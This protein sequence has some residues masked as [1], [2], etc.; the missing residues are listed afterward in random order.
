MNHSFSRIL[1]IMLT[2]ILLV[3]ALRFFTSLNFP[4]PTIN[5]LGDTKRA[6]LG[7]NAP[8][9]QIV[10]INKSNL[11]GFQI[12]MGDTELFFGESLEFALLD[13]DC[14]NLIRQ[15]KRT[16]FSLPIQRDTHFTFDPL[17]KSAGESYCLSVVYQPGFLERKERPYIRATEDER[18]AEFSYTD[19]GK[20]KTYPGRTLQIR[21]LYGATSA[22]ERVSELENRLSQYKPALAKGLMLGLGLLGILLGLIFFFRVARAD[23]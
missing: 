16:F 21:P 20:D 15:S 2:L 5:F 22:S 23:D 12:F 8:L 10:H 19:Y 6:E 3:L 7:K 17:P 18:F 11:S 14:Q 1:L 4:D 13:S 9:T